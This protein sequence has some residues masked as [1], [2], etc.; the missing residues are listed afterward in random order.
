MQILTIKSNHNKGIL[1][2][3]NLVILQFNTGSYVDYLNL[4]DLSF[5]VYNVYGFED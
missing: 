5:S 2:P 4:F 3:E 1:L